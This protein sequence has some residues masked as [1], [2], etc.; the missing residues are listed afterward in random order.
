LAQLG[1]GMVST[2]S[3]ILA[4]NRSLVAIGF[5]PEILPVLRSEPSRLRGFSG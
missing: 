3:S 4:S 5:D 1:A 2:A